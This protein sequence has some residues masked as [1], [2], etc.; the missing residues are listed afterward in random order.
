[1]KESKNRIKEIE[2]LIGKLLNETKGF[3]EL[4]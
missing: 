3:Y 4:K 2:K 1:M